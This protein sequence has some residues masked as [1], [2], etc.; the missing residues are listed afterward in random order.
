MSG[1][2]NP[3]APPVAKGEQ[4]MSD[5]LSNA[6]ADLQEPGLGMGMDWTPRKAAQKLGTIGGDGAVD[7]LMHAVQHHPNE[8]VRMDAAWA[9]ATIGDPRALPALESAASHDSSRTNVRPIAARAV[10]KIRQKP[11]DR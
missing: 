7:A 1:R 3:T 10:R 2:I 4:A 9:L 5:E 8:F 6:I 11:E